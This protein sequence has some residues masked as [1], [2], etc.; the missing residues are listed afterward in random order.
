[1]TP[2]PLVDPAF[3]HLGETLVKGMIMP[4]ASGTNRSKCLC[5]C[6]FVKLSGFVV[7][8]LVPLDGKRILPSF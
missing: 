2:P 5:V 3:K 8:F 1:M 6:L 4:W 7:L